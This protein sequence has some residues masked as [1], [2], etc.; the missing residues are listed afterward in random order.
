MER[1][2]RIKGGKEETSYPFRLLIVIEHRYRFALVDARAQRNRARAGLMDH[3]RCSTTKNEGREDRKESRSKH[4]FAVF[5]RFAFLVGGASGTD[6]METR[7][8]ASSPLVNGDEL[9]CLPSYCT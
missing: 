5:A 1:L 9:Y 2:Q 8:S 6:S 4:F 7:H 3:I